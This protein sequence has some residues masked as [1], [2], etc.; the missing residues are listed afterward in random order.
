[1]ASGRSA[2]RLSK[3]LIGEDGKIYA[4]S[5]KT[6]FAFESNGSIAWSLD[7]DFKCNIGMAPVHG[8]KGKVINSFIIRQ[9]ANLLTTVM[10]LAVFCV[11]TTKLQDCLVYCIL[12]ELFQTGDIWHT[13]SSLLSM[14]LM[15]S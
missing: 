7:L 9:M 2:F 11:S 12:K 6:L 8:G 5:E 3:P 4:C 13:K 10:L 1:M 14:V 15:I